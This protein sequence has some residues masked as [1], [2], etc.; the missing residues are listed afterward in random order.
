[1][2]SKWTAVLTAVAGGMIAIMVMFEIA[3]E[4][5]GKLL[6][7][8][9]LMSLRES[10]YSLSWFLIYLGLAILATLVTLTVGY[11]SGCK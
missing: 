10:T 3:K 6:A 4:K 9:R 8:M 11:G 1:V 2:V 7:A 5:R